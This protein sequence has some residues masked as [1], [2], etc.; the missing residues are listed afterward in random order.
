MSAQRRPVPDRGRRAES[1]RPGGRSGA[2]RDARATDR[3]ALGQAHHA[4]RASAC[5]WGGAATSSSARFMAAVS[6]LR[7][8]DA[9]SL[10]KAPARRNG[11]ALDRRLRLD[12][13]RGAWIMTRDPRTPHPLRHHPAR[14]PTD[15]RRPVLHARETPHRRSARRSRSRLYR[16]RLA[17]CEPHR[18]RVFRR[19]AQDA[20]HDDRLRH[21]QTRGPVGGQ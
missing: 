1:P 16:R 13:G 3:I 6:G 21:D 19:R 17:R 14:R 2:G 8:K 7:T 18:Q 5:P 15:A 10:A 11:Q 12:S 20:R 4:S 9:P